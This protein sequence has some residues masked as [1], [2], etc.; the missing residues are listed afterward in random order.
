MAILIKIEDDRNPGA[1]VDAYAKVIGIHG[2]RFNNG[3]G[4][5][6]AIFAFFASEEAAKADAARIGDVFTLWCDVDL[7]QPMHPQFYAAIKAHDPA[8][9][10]KADKLAVEK[11][12]AEVEAEIADL[13]AKRGKKE[14]KQLEADYDT[15]AAL[16]AK[17]AEVEEERSAI[18][19][20][21]EAARDLRERIRKAQD[22]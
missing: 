21:F 8:D 22:A 1:M 15:E 3:K 14:G 2:E 18:G 19:K 11:K 13:L 10:L 12:A 7:N 20:R 17:L 5:V 9:E 6:E 4:K 16:R